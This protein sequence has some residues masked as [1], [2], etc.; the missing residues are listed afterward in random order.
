M[1]SVAVPLLIVNVPALWL[2]MSVAAAEYVRVVRSIVSPEAKPDTVPLKY[3][4]F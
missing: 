4:R 3:P 1:I 2:Q